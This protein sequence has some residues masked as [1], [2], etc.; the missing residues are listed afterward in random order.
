MLA[1]RRLH[2]AADGEAEGGKAK[3]RARPERVKTPY[4]RLVTRARS[5]ISRIRCARAACCACAL[6]QGSRASS[7][8][9]RC[10]DWHACVISPL[11]GLRP[12][13]MPLW[14]LACA[15]STADLL[16]ER[17]AHIFWMMGTL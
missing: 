17:F 10:Q 13:P 5:L 7:G 4:T 11:L 14:G 3:A 2:T 16:G 9:R 15:L 12:F 8:W 6:L 1:F